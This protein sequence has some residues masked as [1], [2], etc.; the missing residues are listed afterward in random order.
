MLNT[1]GKANMEKLFIS[2]S[3]EDDGFVRVVRMT[4]AAATVP[5]PTTRIWIT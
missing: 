1:S 5:W 4:L 3:S 2:H